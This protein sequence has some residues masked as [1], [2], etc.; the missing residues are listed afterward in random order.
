[1]GHL[2]PCAGP[3]RPNSERCEMTEKQALLEEWNEAQIGCI[4]KSPPATLA[5]LKEWKTK[6]RE[7]CEASFTPLPRLYEGQTWPA[8]RRWA[9][10][11]RFFVYDERAPRPSQYSGGNFLPDREAADEF[12]QLCA[13]LPFVA[14]QIDDKLSLCKRHVDRLEWI[15][16]D[17]IASDDLADAMRLLL[18]RLEKGIEVADRAGAKESRKPPLNERQAEAMEIIREHGPIPEK[19]IVKR[20][21]VDVG[22]GTFRK[23]DVPVLKRHG[24]ASSGRGYYMPT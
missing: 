9:H 14:K 24:V 6:H 16:D 3:G 13:D 12:Q 2:S 19:D 5:A 10:V 1:M 23:H 7:W 18:E 11:L 20:L 21:S 8:L 4:K 22:T 15:P 17:L